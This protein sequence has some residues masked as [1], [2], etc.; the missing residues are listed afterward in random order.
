MLSLRGRGQ[1][2]YQ[3]GD[4]M[5]TTASCVMC[6][7]AL[8]GVVNRKGIV[9]CMSDCMEIASKLHGRLEQ[10]L[11]MGYMG[12]YDIMQSSLFDNISAMV[13]VE[14]A[15]ILSPCEV[16][17]KE[18]AITPMDVVEKLANGGAAVV[19]SAGHSMA[20]FSLQ[21]VFYLFDSMG[22]ECRCTM[23]AP[24][25]AKALQCFGLGQKDVSFLQIREGLARIR[26]TKNVMK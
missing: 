2:T 13:T 4:T 26:D 25:A 21:G 6:L 19:T 20:F 14:E 24:Q 23:D 7:A 18:Y 9:K 11:H 10:E 17:A 12:V 15:V 3:N 5:C 8:C 1:R 22:S 16:W